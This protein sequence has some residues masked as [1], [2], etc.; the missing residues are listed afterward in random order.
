MKVQS[1]RG[2]QEIPALNAVLQGIASDGGL[3]VPETFPP[4]DLDEAKQCAE[5]SYSDLCGYVLSLFF[6]LGREDLSALARSAYAGFDTP[7]TVPLRPLPEN[8][9]VMELTHGPTLAFKDMALQVLP[10]LTQA[11]LEKE[12]T[13]ENILVL[14]ATSGDTGK[15]AMAGFMDV[16]RTAIFVFY[17]DKGVAE[18]QRLQMVTQKGD[19]TG[20]CAV[21]GNFDDAQT[22]VKRLFASPQFRDAARSAGWTPSSANSINFGRLVP[23]IAYYVY[24]YAKLLA[25]GKL[26]DGETVNCCVP[27]GNFGN[28]LAAYYARR[29]GIPIGR[30]VC[31]SNSNNVLTDFFRSGSY[32]AGRPFHKTMSPSMDILISSNLERF[33]YEMCGRDSAMVRAWMQALSETGTYAVPADMLPAMQELIWADWLSEEET[34]QI[35]RDVFNSLG[36]L[37]DPHTAVAQGVCLKYRSATGDRRPMITVSTANPYKFPQDV[38]HALTD[39]WVEEPFAAARELSELTGTQIPPQIAELQQLPVLHDGVTDR[40][41]M[42]DAVLRFLGRVKK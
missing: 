16:S 31:A 20:V 19:N 15:A 8:E 13:E 38:L 12:D 18:M 36:Y 26:G 2:G 4:I 24:A 27:T 1:T 14:T 3:F 41:T 23:Q 25:D 33:L 11:A 6:D 30:L 9:Y 40:D 5:K 22:G 7:D 39:S 21:R 10:R 29:M 28:I 17:P 42:G 35:I 34:A 37:M 32:N